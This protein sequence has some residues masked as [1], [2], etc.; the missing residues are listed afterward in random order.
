MPRQFSP[1]I[2]TA[3]RLVEG[4]VVYLTA[5]NLWSGD[6]A[7]AEVLQDEADAEL[8]LLEGSAQV[9]VIVGAYLADVTEHPSGPM[10]VHFREAFRQSGPSNYNHTKQTGRANV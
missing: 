9:N 10:P 4:D 1:K 8:R 5:Q 7:A 2:V 6:L 3:N